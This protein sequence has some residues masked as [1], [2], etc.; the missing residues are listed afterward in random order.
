MILAFDS[1]TEVALRRGNSTELIGYVRT[2]N[3][4]V[5]MG[6]TGVRPVTFDETL[7]PLE[8]FIAFTDSD[9]GQRS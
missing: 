5:S 3:C 8:R 6:L 9:S 2:N 1:L 4:I 7:Q